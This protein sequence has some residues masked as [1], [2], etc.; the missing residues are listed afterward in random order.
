MVCNDNIF[1]FN[2]TMSTHFDGLF[3]CLKGY[4][5]RQSLKT[6]VRSRVVLFSVYIK[7]E[8]IR[9]TLRERG[10]GSTLNVN[11]T[12]SVIRSIFQRSLNQ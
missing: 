10:E 9:L 2:G 3:D 4:F 6:V 1:V 5:N 7:K 12:L 8:N 11:L